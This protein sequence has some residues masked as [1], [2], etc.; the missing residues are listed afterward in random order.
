MQGNRFVRRVKERT[1]RWIHRRVK[2][3]LIHWSECEWMT[4]FISHKNKQEIHSK[5]FSKLYQLPQGRRQYENLSEERGMFLGRRTEDKRKAAKNSHTST[6]LSFSRQCLYVEWIL[7][8]VLILIVARY[9]IVLLIICFICLCIYDL[10]ILDTQAIFP[11]ML[12][13]RGLW[14]G[15]SYDALKWKFCQNLLTL[16]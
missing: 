5:L 12:V 9:N 14:I 4:E 2:Y 10:K 1:R 16:N 11:L 8:R 3:L 7:R 15:S 13:K 6:N